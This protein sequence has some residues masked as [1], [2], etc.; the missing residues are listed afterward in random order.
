MQIPNSQG[1]IRQINIGDYAGEIWESFNLDFSTI[2]GKIKTSKQLKRILTDAQLGTPSGIVDLIIWDSKYIIVTE[3]GMYT[4]SVTNDPTNSANWSA[5]SIAEDLDL[6]SSVVVFNDG[7]NTRLRIALDTNIAEWNGAATYDATWWTVDK[8]GTALNA[9]VPHMMEVVQSQKETLYVTDGSR[10][11]YY[12][13]GA[14]S[15]QIVELDS[16]VTASCLAAGLSGAMWVGTYSETTGKAFVYE[17][18]TNEQVGGTPVYRQAYPVEGRAVLAIWVMDNTPYIITETG[19][20]QQFNGAGFT[21]VAQFP[22][23][24]SGR[25]LDGVIPGQIQDSSRVRPIHPRGVKNYGSYT[26]ILLN[27][28]SEADRYASTNRLHSGVWEF[29]HDTNSL[30]HKFAVKSTDDENGEAVL[31]GTGPLLIVDNSYTFMLAGCD[32]TSAASVSEMYAVQN[33]YGTSWFTTPEIL[34][35]VETDSF[36]RVIHKANIKDDGV[37]YTLY[38]TTKRDTIYGTANWVSSTEFVT[39]DDW[40][41]VEIGDLVRVSEGYGAGHWAMVDNKSSSATTYTIKLS[42]EIGL[43]G[44]TSYV[45]SDNY[46][47]VSDTYTATDGEHKRVGLDVQSAWIQVMVILEGDIEYRMFD[48]VDMTKS[49]R[50]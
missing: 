22:F 19:A 31:T 10:V 46:N 18:Y 30:T 42:R 23:L 49:N 40:S 14:A 7:T 50:K 9:G 43:N 45:Y 32:P 13:K 21:T 26:Y 25:P 15:T 4:C 47:L 24:L 1:Q 34:S 2:P 39:T 41:T 35:Q 3:D 48:L 28:M 36:L 12:E 38:R 29:N 6:S 8:A 37:I 44:Q 27:A 17:I 11:Q 16:N 33:T 20:I 5:T